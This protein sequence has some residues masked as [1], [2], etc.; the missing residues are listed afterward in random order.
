MNIDTR[1]STKLD[2]IQDAPEPLRKALLDS[3]PSKES[4]RFLV[5]GARNARRRRT[6]DSLSGW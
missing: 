1:F 6:G 4:V 5:Q 3:F 2:A